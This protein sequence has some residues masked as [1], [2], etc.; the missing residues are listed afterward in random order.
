M[1][2]QGGQLCQKCFVP[3]W[4]GVYSLKKENTFDLYILL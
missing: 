4:D 2:F 1:H 3:F